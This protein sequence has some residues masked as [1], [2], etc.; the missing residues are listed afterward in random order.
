MIEISTA[1]T[2][3]DFQQARQ[4]IR[5]YEAWLGLDLEFQGFQQEMEA[6]ERMYGPPGGSMLLAQADGEPV[7]CVGLRDLG[8]GVCEMKRMFVRPAHHGGGVGSRLM[9]AFME[10]AGRLGYRSVRLDTIP[11]LEGAFRL[12]RKAGFRE[13]EPYR[14][15][16]DPEAVF[17]ALDVA[18]WRAIRGG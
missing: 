18:E 2:P 1:T 17:M 9:A 7:G 4:L 16:P 15:N 8:G 5:E 12:Y 11:R 6:L 13:I 3:E 10:T 14:Y